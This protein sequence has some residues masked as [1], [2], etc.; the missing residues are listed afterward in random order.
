M[1]YRWGLSDRIQSSLYLFIYLFV[2]ELQNLLLPVDLTKNHILKK[3]LSLRSIT[4]N[5]LFS[6]TALC[7]TSLTPQSYMTAPDSIQIP[8]LSLYWSWVESLLV[9]GCRPLSAANRVSHSKNSVSNPSYLSLTVPWRA[10]D[11]EIY[12]RWLWTTRNWGHQSLYLMYQNMFGKNRVTFSNVE[13]GMGSVAGKTRHD[14]KWQIKCWV[15]P[16][17]LLW[18]VR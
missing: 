15:Y 6:V 7:I 12:D 14:I 8:F 4:S 16:S 5:L 3:K 18:A 10:V 11:S 2:S 13:K 17:S 1:G 9:L